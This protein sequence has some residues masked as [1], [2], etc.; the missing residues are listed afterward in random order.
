MPNICTHLVFGAQVA[1]AVQKPQESLGELYFLG[2]LGPDYYFYDRLPPTPFVPHRKKHGNVL[3]GLDCGMLFDAL[4]AHADPSLRPYLYGFLTHIALDSTV[5]P[6]I[7]AEH[8]GSAHS[9]FEGVIDSVVYAQTKNA[10]PYRR[11]LFAKPD[12]TPVDA[13]LADVSAALCGENVKGAYTRSFR[14]YTRLIPLMF[15]PKSRRYRFLR[16]GERLFKRP[17]IVSDFLIG[18]GHEDPEDCMNLSRK[19]WISPWEPDRVRDESVPMLLDKAKAL[20]AALITAFD[21]GDDETL[22]RLLQ[23]RS[24]RKGEVV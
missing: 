24:M 19:S 2:C 14:K 22:H 20:A 7:E 18:P 6:Y 16:F 15:D 12:V 8:R 9:R 5:H 4:A 13:L 3:H 10:F 1:E 11:L 21:A 17:G 23:G